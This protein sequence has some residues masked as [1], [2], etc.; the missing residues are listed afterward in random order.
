MSTWGKRLKTTRHVAGL[1]TIL[2]SLG[3]SVELT[4]K[5]STDTAVLRA[6]YSYA[7]TIA[8]HCYAAVIGGL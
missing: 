5:L 6:R 2:N 8:S 1:R 4:Q 3:Q 7:V